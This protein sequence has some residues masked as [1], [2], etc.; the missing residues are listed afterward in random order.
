MQQ[1]L[2]TTEVFSNYFVEV[3]GKIF[4]PIPVPII[5]VDRE[6][7]VIMINQ[8]FA[9]FLGKTKEEII[10]EK[11]VDVD[12]TSRFP[13]VFKSKTEEIAWKHQFSNGRTAIV[14]RIPVLDEKNDVKYGFGLLLFQD[15][16]EL[17]DIIEKNKLIETEL[18]YTKKQLKKI[19]GA[20]YSWDNII[21]SSNRMVQSIYMSRKAAQTTSNVL[22]LGE[23]G[24]GK[25]L[26][27]HAIHNAGD[28][29]HENFVKINCAAIPTEL[30]ESELF[31]YEEGA[32]TGAK[33]G[34][35]IGKFE[36]A[37]RG[38]IF[39]DE[40]GELPLSMQAKLLRVLQEREIERVGGTKTIPV[41]VRVIA[42]TNHNLQNMVKENAFRE[43]LYYRLNV[44]EIVIPSLRERDGDLEELAN[45]L[46]LKVSNELGKFMSGISREA[47]AH[48]NA[49]EWPG[50]VRELENVLERAVNLADSDMILPIHLPYSVTQ[51]N[52]RK[53]KK[54]GSLKDIIEET[55]KEMIL[56]VMKETKGN[57]MKT[58]GRLDIS[59]S[60]LY[61]KLEKYGIE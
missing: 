40:I 45:K 47:M 37:K 46:L 60:S 14:H 18:D 35:K 1:S 30:M 57:K 9:D 38:S 55:E 8:V 21:G 49:Y 26:F 36:L 5:L 12:P 56:N 22:L 51:N 11:V 28:R 6:T 15:V 48:L 19:L 42:A 50:N 54:T 29:A 13:D 44:M 20:K 53:R 52:V 41:D 43:D 3:M 25:E 27:A 33:R 10:G 61:D 16:K 4:D 32:F 58:A 59:R 2:N 39:L 17:K 34:G 23:S 31:G 24:T 7:K